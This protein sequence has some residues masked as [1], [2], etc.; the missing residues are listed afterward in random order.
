MTLRNFKKETQQTI[1]TY[2][3]T[4]IR[5]NLNEKQAMPFIQQM[6]S[7]EKICQ[8]IYKTQTPHERKEKIIEYDKIKTDL[9]KDLEIH[10]E[11]AQQYPKLAEY[12]Y[13]IHLE[14]QRKQDPDVPRLRKPNVA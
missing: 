6:L 12:W 13:N 11:I 2:R 10:Q 9:Y 1:E 3:H 5:T 8:Q 4:A 7:L 14:E